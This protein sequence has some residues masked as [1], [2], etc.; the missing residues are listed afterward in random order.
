MSDGTVSFPAGSRVSG[1][2][3]E[4]EIGRGGMA[5]VFRARD[6]QLGRLVALKILAPALAGDE[7]FQRRFVRESQ[8]VAG[9]DDP[10]IVPVFAA[11]EADGVLFIAMRYV[12]GGDVQSMLGREGPLSAS[13]VASIISPVASALDAAHAAGLLHRDVKPSNMLVDVLPGR[14]DHVYL[15]D[16]GLSKGVASTTGTTK[17]GEVIGTVEYMPPEQIAGEQA[18]GRGD[19]YALACAAIAMLTGEPPFR[20]D[21]SAAVLYAHM[22]E[23]PPPATSRRPDLPPAADGV[24]AKALAK[25]PGDRYASC[26]EFA[27]ALRA[28]LGFEPY[29]AGP[30]ARSEPPLPATGS[31]YQPTVTSVPLPGVLAPPDRK[32]GR[33]RRRVVVAAVL[34]GIT[35]A[36]AA[37]LTA[38]LLPGGAPSHQASAHRTGTARPVAAPV[39]VTVPITAKSAQA[40]VDG[41]VYVYYRYAGKTS[42]EISGAV[43][44]PVAG[45]VVRLYAQQFPFAQPPA[46]AGE[47]LLQPD[48]TESAGTES[49]G[50]GAAYQFQVTPSLATRYHVELFRSSTSSAPLATSPVTTVYVQLEGPTTTAPACSQTQTTCHITVQLETFVPPSVLA[51]EMG[52]P[53]YAYF[54]ITKAASKPPA[55]PK[56][57]T[58]GAGG[59]RVSAA[60]RVSGGEY[61]DTLTLTF[62]PGSG[63]YNWQA[64]T[65][66][67][68]AVATDG[69]GLP[70]H[71]GCGDGRVPYPYNYLG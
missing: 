9:I 68:D 13:R 23:P 54:G 59:A 24:L 43:S 36:A 32:P 11:G 5:V 52:K 29:L 33:P 35:I 34:A 19:Q 27:D 20:R 48:G 22:H 63:Y 46:P 71:H 25:A 2:R 42:A 28:A 6:E 3:L 39:P 18:D 26:A 16:F 57:L 61:A 62:S 49:A 4:Q 60:R 10:H 64:V 40:P 17:T 15:S 69:I 45:E 14:P 1:Y 56:W 21:T 66:T 8:A 53:M 70:G 12:A 47:M 37:V 7:A 55:P 30:K 58:L 51:T 50:T 41:Y 65:C 38:V 44:K 31:A 67:K